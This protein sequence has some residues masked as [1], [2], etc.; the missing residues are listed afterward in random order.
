MTETEKQLTYLLNGKWS[1]KYFCKLAVLDHLRECYQKDNYL[2]AT[3]APKD[4][5]GYK[6]FDKELTDLK[7]TIDL[8]LQGKEELYKTRVAKFWNNLDK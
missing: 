7:I 5:E 3:D 6:D 2:K 8:Y 4:S 1:N